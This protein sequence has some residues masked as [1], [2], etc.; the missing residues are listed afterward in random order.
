MS[1]IVSIVF[2]SKITTHRD[3]S[4]LPNLTSRLL[5]RVTQHPR[6]WLIIALTSTVFCRDICIMSALPFCSSVLRSN[7]THRY[8]IIY[9]YP[10][11]SHVLRRHTFI[12]VIHTTGM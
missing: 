6:S 2:N 8:S 1:Y 3:V 4:M 10:S 12:T 9:Q 11:V 5:S 7:N